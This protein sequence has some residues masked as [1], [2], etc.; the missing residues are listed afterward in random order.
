[1]VVETPG[2]RVTRRSRGVSDER[3]RGARARPGPRPVVRARARTGGNLQSPRPRSHTLRAFARSGP[4]AGERAGGPTRG[5]DAN[6]QTRP[7]GVVAVAVVVPVARRF[8]KDFRPG[9]RPSGERRSALVL[10]ATTSFFLCRSPRK[11]GGGPRVL[12]RAARLTEGPLKPR[13]RD[14]LSLSPRERGGPRRA[15]D[16]YGNVS[17]AFAERTRREKRLP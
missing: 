15:R 11:R 4:W 5:R 13:S 7:T 9:S 1:M 6:G 2:G 14:L 8:F 12:G 3:E 10:D 17:R 16:T